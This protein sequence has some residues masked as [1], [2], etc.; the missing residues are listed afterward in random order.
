MIFQRGSFLD[1]L[2]MIFVRPWFLF[3]GSTIASSFIEKSRFW[4][5]RQSRSPWPSSDLSRHHVCVERVR[6]TGGWRDSQTDWIVQCIRL[7]YVERYVCYKWNM[8]LKYM[9]SSQYKF[10]KVNV[11]HKVIRLFLFSLLYV[12]FIK[13]HKPYYMTLKTVC[14]LQPWI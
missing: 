8:V 3:V 2:T 10:Q 11:V 7:Q 14:I 9:Q 12:C 1:I 6:E 5:H 13:L 4:I